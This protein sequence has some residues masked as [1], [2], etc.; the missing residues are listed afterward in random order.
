MEIVSIITPS[1]VYDIDKMEYLL[2]SSR[3]LDI[4]LEVI[5]V[6]KEWKGFFSKLE[7]ITDYC[8]STSDAENRIIIMTDAY[9]TFYYRQYLLL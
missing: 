5:G 4:N 1:N 2:S 7:W 9:D 3:T 6:G 8:N